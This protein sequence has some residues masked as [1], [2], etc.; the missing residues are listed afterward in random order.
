MYELIWATLYRLA[1]FLVR[2]P[3][4][5]L[6]LKC[7]EIFALFYYLL[8]RKDRS[9]LRENLRIILGEKYREKFV[10]NTYKNFAHYLI[11]F[12]RIKED[13]HSF[14][15]KYFRIEN[16]EVIEKALDSSSGGVAALSMHLGNWELGGGYLA[17]LNYKISAIALDHSVH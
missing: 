13:N 11:D 12:M 16:R 17:F 10:V 14:F 3:P 15:Q 7:G 6:V 8:A 2:I 1:I 5:C 9:I 4:R